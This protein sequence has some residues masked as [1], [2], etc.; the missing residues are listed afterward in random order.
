[1]PY[2]DKFAVL[3]RCQGSGGVAD[4][5]FNS[6]V[7]DCFPNG[8]VWRSRKTNPVNKWYF[9]RASGVWQIPDTQW[10]MFWTGNVVDSESAGGEEWKERLEDYIDVCRNIQPHWADTQRPPD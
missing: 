8:V 9:E 7:R 4:I 5:L 1:V 6:M 10:T 3:K 2:L